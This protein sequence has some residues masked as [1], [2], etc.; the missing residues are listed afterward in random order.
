M[1]WIY[2]ENVLKKGE[3]MTRSQLHRLFRRHRGEFIRLAREL[4]LSP[5]TISGWFQGRVDSER[6]EEAVFARAKELLE[7]DAQDGAAKARAQRE[8]AKAQA[9]AQRLAS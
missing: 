2:T 5:T 6:I 4:G 8:L 1:V 3:G 7:K 9:A